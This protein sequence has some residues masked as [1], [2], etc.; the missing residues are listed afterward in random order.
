MCTPFLKHIKAD[1]LIPPANGLVSHINL[2][3]STYADDADTDGCFELFS[4]NRS[5]VID[6][7]DKL[8]SFPELL[9]HF[10]GG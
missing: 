10:G 7:V 4:P 6:T 2:F 3:Q 9:F 5:N 1:L 8:L